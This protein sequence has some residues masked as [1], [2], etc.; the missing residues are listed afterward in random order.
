MNSKKRILVADDD[1]DLRDMIREVLELEDFEVIE[2]GNGED[3]LRFAIEKKPD[4]ILF[5]IIM[6]RMDGVI[7][8]QKLRED[9]WG[10]NAA[11]I[12]LS[13]IGSAQGIARVIDYNVTTYLVK[14]D[15][16]LE[17]IVVRVKEKLNI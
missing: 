2:A 15:W 9:D 3:A 12:A 1:I 8:M 13:N 14:N 4:L 5:D 10:R 6:P 17:E 16:K 7:F 11:V